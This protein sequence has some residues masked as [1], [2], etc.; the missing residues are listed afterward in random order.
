MIFEREGWV[1][2][3]FT[4]AIGTVTQAVIMTWLYFMIFTSNLVKM[5][6]QLSPKS[7]HMETRVPM[8]MSLKQ[9]VNCGFEESLFDILKVAHKSG[10]IILLLAT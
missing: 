10:L 3:G 1:P 4:Q 7:C 6:M 2:V 9:W 5:V 8:V